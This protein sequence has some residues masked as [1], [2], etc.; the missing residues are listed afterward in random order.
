MLLCHALALQERGV[1]LL[2]DLL[3]W[4]G[5]EVQSIAVTEITRSTIT[6]P[7]LS[8]EPMEHRIY[9]DAAD[10]SAASTSAGRL[11]LH[12]GGDDPVAA[13]LEAGM[14]EDELN[15]MVMQAYVTME[16]VGE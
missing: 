7:S 16:G 12:L 1:P 6:L 13:L 15:R 3:P 2:A 9:H 4:E 14:S 10:C 11:R 8:E 5:N